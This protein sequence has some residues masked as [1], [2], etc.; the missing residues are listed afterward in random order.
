[1]VRIEIL[2]TRDPDA[3]CEM[4]VWVDGVRVDNVTVEDIDPGRGYE[5]DDWDESTADV[6]TI[7][8]YTP[9]FREAVVAVRNAYS[10]NRYIER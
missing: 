5:G 7:E 1:M 8:H 2:H 10:D 4:T 3:S 9:E 6:A